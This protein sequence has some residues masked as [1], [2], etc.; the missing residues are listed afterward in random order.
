LSSARVALLMFDFTDPIEPTDSVRFIAPV[1]GVHI[2]LNLLSKPF[3]SVFVLVKIADEA[4][5][6][7][8]YL[9]LI[10]SS[11]SDSFRLVTVSPRIV[12]TSFLSC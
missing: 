5:D 7:L 3:K 10:N 9:A 2:V 11:R 6:G 1:G 8:L 12:Q 4:A